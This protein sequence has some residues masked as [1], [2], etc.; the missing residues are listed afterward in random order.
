MKNF[1]FRG[2]NTH[3]TERAQKLCALMITKLVNHSLICG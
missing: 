1:K 3:S 2:K